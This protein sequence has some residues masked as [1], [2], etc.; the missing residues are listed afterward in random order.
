MRFGLLAKLTLP[1]VALAVIGLG[2][3]TI[4]GYRMSSEAI[5]SSVYQQQTQAADSI[6]RNAR[7]WIDSRTLEVTGWAGSSIYQKALEDGFLG[8]TAR[9]AASARLQQEKQNYPMYLTILVAN[10]NGE[11]VSSSEEG[12]KNIDYILSSPEFQ[13][14]KSGT[15]SSVHAVADQISGKTTSIL[16]APILKN[17]TVAGVLAAIVDLNSFGASFV[18]PM[19]S[20]DTGKAEIF[21]TDGAVFLS[22]AGDQELQ[23]NVQKTGILERIDAADSGALN[24]EDEEKTYQAAYR[25]VEGLPWIVMAS[26]QE[27]E[28][29]APIRTARMISA[30]TSF[31]VAL[32]IAGGVIVVV[33]TILKPIRQAVES[34]RDLSEGNGD[35][36]KRLKI[37]SRDEVSDLA[38]YFNLFVEKLHSVVKRVQN[39]TEQVSNAALDLTSITEQTNTILVRQRS[40][41]E[42]IASAVTEMS[43]TAR[44]VAENAAEAAKFAEKADQQAEEGNHVVEKTISA[45]DGL[46]EVVANSAQVIVALRNESQNVGSV[47]DV[48]KGIAEQTNLLALNA[49]IEAARAGESGRGFAVVADEVRTLAQRTQ[50]STQ[51]IQQII[52]SLQG[53]AE[54]ASKSIEDSHNRAQATVKQ[55]LDAGQA[56]KSITQA[57]EHITDMNHQIASAAE[58]QSLVTAEVTRNV[59]NIHEVTEET[60]VTSERTSK[61]SQ[62]LNHSS[63]ELKQ[64]VS[65]FRV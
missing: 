32:V 48:I 28:V 18:N 36:T 9:K 29:L 27:E 5:E 14:A 8:M 38:C 57:V 51:E 47:L 65:Q 12:G 20:G 22:S 49:A 37:Q 16:Y 64:I 43:A 6:A 7:F 21:L 33:R 19:K 53:K 11:V 42:Q 62:E 17:E 31:L 30:L 41:T 24:F 55:A 34:L 26:A 3:T 25:K 59:T 63:S 2:V 1:T 46:A 40:E 44:S 13:A 10:L 23:R 45:I 50:S 15:F 61:S 54:K 35:L 58:E 4:I 60:K 56:L 39:S 52:D